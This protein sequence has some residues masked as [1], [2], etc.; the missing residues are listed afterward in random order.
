MEKFLE[1]CLSLLAVGQGLEGAVPLVAFE[2]RSKQG[3]LLLGRPGLQLRMPRQLEGLRHGCALLG[4]RTLV[5]HPGCSLRCFNPLPV[6]QLLQLQVPLHA[7]HNNRSLRAHSS[8]M[9]TLSI[10]IVGGGQRGRHSRPCTCLGLQSTVVEVRREAALRQL[11]RI[12]LGPD[13]G[14][15][16]VLLC[17]VLRDADARGGLWGLVLVVVT[18]HPGL[19]GVGL[20]VGASW[21][22]PRAPTTIGARLTT[23]RQ[24]RLAPVLT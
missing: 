6:C 7:A 21:G 14:K 2:R 10:V 4:P 5:E 3:S 24:R 16:G 13:G 18:P 1:L 19:A 20:Q 11:L 22:S 17:L 15:T 12:L 9:H 23:A 8:C